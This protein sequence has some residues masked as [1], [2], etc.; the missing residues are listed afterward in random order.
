MIEAV[1]HLSILSIPEYCVRSLA[2]VAGVNKGKR[3]IIMLFATLSF[4]PSTQAS[5]C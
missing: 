3:D 1:L 4:P 2:S 5:V